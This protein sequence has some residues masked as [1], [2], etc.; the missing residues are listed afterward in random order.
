MLSKVAQKY[1]NLVLS[2]LNFGSLIL[3]KFL[4]TR[5]TGNSYVFFDFGAFS[6]SKSISDE[7]E[8][9]GA[10]FVR[11]ARKSLTLEISLSVSLATLS[12]SS[13][14]RAKFCL[15]PFFSYITTKSSNNCITSNIF[16]SVSSR[17]VNRSS[18]F[19]DSSA[20]SLTS[21]EYS[22]VSC[23][24]LIRFCF[25]RSSSVTPHASA[26]TCSPL[27]VSCS[28]S[29]IF[30]KSSTNDTNLALLPIWPDEMPKNYS[31]TNG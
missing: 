3:S 28:P 31:K 7:A 2:P 6:S 20:I 21:R 19:T 26:L 27:S 8:P 18:I 9:I 14:V 1:S 30:L 24:F 5:L 16:S 4:S 29:S 11:E 13:S 25:F 12:I 22:F 10:F 15:S 17:V 23:I